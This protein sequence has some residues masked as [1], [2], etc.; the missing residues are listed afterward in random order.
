MRDLFEI[1]E[2]KKPSRPIKVLNL[3]AGLGGNRKLWENC[4]VTA[5]EMEP[6]I[7][8]IYQRLNPEDTVVVGDAHQYLLDHHESFDFGWSSPPC[9]T[10]S[11]MSKATRHKVRKYPD[12]SLYQEVLFLQHH[13]KGRFVVENVVP[14]YTPLI[15]PSKII[16]RHMF[17][18]NFQIRANDVPTPTGFIQKSNQ[19]G[20]L[21]LQNWLGIHYDGNVYYGTNHCPAQ[22]LRNCVHPQMG[23]EIY[24]SMLQ[25]LAS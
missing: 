7:A 6:E 2:Q 14:F 8:E 25:S 5:V 19:E 18:S 24:N 10:H 9:Q 22:I 4:N 23:I 16:G 11:K 3:Y 15:P 13:F 12:M 21:A 20:K 17:W 1:P